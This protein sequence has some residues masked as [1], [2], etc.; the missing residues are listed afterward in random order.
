[1]DRI[2]LFYYIYCATSSV[3]ERLRR[4][5]SSLQIQVEVEFAIIM[6]LGEV[7]CSTMYE[8]VKSIEK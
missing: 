2:K 7:I 1:M 5:D 8:L 3:A 6:W 4:R